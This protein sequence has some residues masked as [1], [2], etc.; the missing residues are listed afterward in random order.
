[1]ADKKLTQ[2][3]V[4]ANAIAYMKGEPTEVTPKDFI[5]FFEERIEVLER[6]N[7]NRKPTKTQ[8]EN[9]VLKSQIAEV[10][11]VEKGQTATEVLTALG[12]DGLSN[13]KVSS[14]LRQMAEAGVARKEMDKKKALW[15][16]V[17]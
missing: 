3:E 12:Q 2:K 9:E 1:M 7:E 17:Q 10:L 11:S 13:Q 5:K 4:Y 6:K 15:Y 16:L 8:E 14:M